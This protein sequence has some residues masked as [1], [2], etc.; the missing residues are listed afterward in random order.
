MLYSLGSVLCGVES[1]Q[2]GHMLGVLAMTA[3]GCHFP[4]RYGRHK[5]AS[6]ASFALRHTVPTQATRKHGM[7]SWSCRSP[8]AL[9]ILDDA[10]C[11]RINRTAALLFPTA[12]ASSLIQPVEPLSIIRQGRRSMAEC[13]LHFSIPTP[14]FPKIWAAGRFWI[15]DTDLGV[16]WGFTVESSE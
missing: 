5:K 15:M 13:G 6:E 16:A 14:F 11:G 10:A 4:P 9:S 7:F 1:R 8:S 12:T 3:W 2:F